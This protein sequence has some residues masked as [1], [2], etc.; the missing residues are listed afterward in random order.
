M[1][2]QEAVRLQA[3]DRYLLGELSAA[4]R[5]A[6]ESHYFGCPDCALEVMAGEQL[7]SSLRAVL[8]QQRAGTASAAAPRGW[9]ERIFG[10]P[11]LAV[12]MAA[13]CVL[14]TLIAYQNLVV[15]PGLRSQLAAAVA[16]QPYQSFALRGLARGEEIPLTLARGARFAGLRLDL[17][18]QYRFRGYRGEILDKSGVLLFS[19]DS[20]PPHQP[21]DP[22]EF[23]IPGANLPAGVYTLV[24]R[25]LG[26]GQPGGGA[27]LG[28]YRFSVSFK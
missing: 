1:D 8:R 3:A 25:G 2:H 7:R 10:R 20:P 15:L 6:F 21:G 27:E 5:E 14:L 19:V 17:D 9:L 28:R 23:L 22:L 18:P 26:A 24:L 11:A 12:S 16:P 13:A 4:E